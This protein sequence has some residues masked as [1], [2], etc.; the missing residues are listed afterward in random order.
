MRAPKKILNQFPPTAV[1]LA[2]ADILVD[3]GMTFAK[4]LRSAGVKV[5]TMKYLSNIHGFFGRFIF[6]DAGPDSLADVVKIELTGNNRF[7]DGKFLNDFDS[8]RSKVKKN[9][10]EQFLEVL[11]F[12]L[13]FC[14]I[15][16]IIF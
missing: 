16:C 8:S 9:K 11:L 6:G 15:F 5:H 10:T 7:T 14:T 2:G 13:V 1:Y 3:E 4:K 12:F